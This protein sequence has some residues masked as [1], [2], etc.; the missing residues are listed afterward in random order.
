MTERPGAKII[1]TEEPL[2]DDSSVSRPSKSVP[3]KSQSRPRSRP[4]ARR[5]PVLE[6]AREGTYWVARIW[7]R[8]VFYS[9]SLRGRRPQALRLI[10][11]ENWPGSSDRGAG[12]VDGRFRFL[13]HTLK[14][15]DAFSA[16]LEAGPAWQA[17]LHSFDWLR[18]MRAVG[19]EAAR[20][21]ARNCVASWISANPKWDPLTWRPDVLSSRLCN[22]LTH[23]EFVSA[24]ADASFASMFLDNIARQ[25]KH[26]RRVAPFVPDGL[27]RM[28]VVKARVYAALCLPGGARYAPRLVRIL[29]AMCER[30]ILPDGGHI[31]R[32]PKAQMAALRHLIDL[33]A[34]LKASNIDVPEALQRAIDRAAPMLR[35]YRHGDGGLALFNGANEGEAWLIDVVLTKAE[36]RGQPV[37]SAPHTGFERFMANR[38]LVIADS[39]APSLVGKGAHAGTLSFEMS[40]A[41][42]RIIV[43][44]GAYAGRDA[45]WRL[46]QRS[47]A[48]H[49]TM[50]VDDRNST[51]LREDGSIGARPEN[52]T[53][54][55]LE[56][57]GNTWL[58]L[59]HDGYQGAL[60]LVHRRRIYVNASGT[61]VRGEDTLEGTGEHR[62]AIRF[63]LHPSVKASL[64]KDGAS[65]LLRLPDKSGWRMRCSGG[66]ASLQESIYLGDG[67]ESRRSEQI[68]ISGGTSQGEA[69]VKWALTRLNDS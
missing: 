39:G 31:E 54:E 38:T 6:M 21:Q 18:D 15:E 20:I 45:R 36:S 13:N 61:D 11:Q 8:G 42:Q 65:V 66:V 62:F 50:I 28:I 26:L 16:A 47:T 41:K 46:A 68:V 3:P 10:P 30:Q 5:F 69:K 19:T 32:S 29:A 4:L 67:H 44:C 9:N 23:A 64:V 59:S 24:G 37:T 27:E 43:N 53:A 55:R 57:D 49:S 56:A 17:E 51:E 33:R 63:H 22:W 48:A 34:V 1:D 7:F 2:L 52:V 12:L 14:A 60:G 25:V 40:V 35:F 58:D